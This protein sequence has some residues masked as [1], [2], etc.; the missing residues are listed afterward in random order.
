MA[1]APTPRAVFPEWHRA[2]R[3]WCRSRPDHSARCGSDV[4]AR[5]AAQHDLSTCIRTGI[6]VGLAIQDEGIPGRPGTAPRRSRFRRSAIRMRRT[7]EA[8]AQ[9]I[10]SAQGLGGGAS[11]RQAAVP[12]TAV[13]PSA[14]RR[15]GSQI[16]APVASIDRV[17]PHHRPGTGETTTPAITSNSI[18]AARHAPRP[19]TTGA[20]RTPARDPHRSP[21]VFAGTPAQ[22]AH[23]PARA[24]VRFRQSAVGNW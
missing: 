18:A 5:R 9:R 7:I 14:A 12:H 2:S 1:R 8:S 24:G 21:A 13:G 16:I 3:R 10:A 19:S 17:M 23:R 20:V 15:P 22:R 6:A 4:I 11:R